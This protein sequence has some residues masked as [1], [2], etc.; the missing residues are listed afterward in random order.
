MCVHAVTQYQLH[1]AW[2]GCPGSFQRHPAG[3]G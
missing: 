3:S 1:Y 2:V